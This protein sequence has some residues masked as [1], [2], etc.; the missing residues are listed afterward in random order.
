MM[1]WGNNNAMPYFS[2]LTKP[3]CKCTPGKTRTRWS[4]QRHHFNPI[5]TERY[6]T[7]DH[8]STD[9]NKID[10]I[11]PTPKRLCAGTPKECMYCKFDIPHPS[12]T[13]SDWSSK[14]WDGR[15]AKAKEQMPLFDFRLQEQQLQKTLQDMT[16]DVVP[17]KQ[18]MDL[19]NRMQDL[20]LEQNQDM[21]NKTDILAPPLD[22]PEVKHE[23]TGK[24]ELT[25]MYNM[26]NQEVRLHHKEEKYGIYVSTF[27]YE[28]DDSDLDS[29]MDSNSNATAYLFLE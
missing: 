1:A 21:Q 9:F 10:I 12:I 19:I 24:D 16:Q 15:K 8:D 5:K 14:D 17:D 7:Q 23:E 13:L 27:G 2:T 4:N 25:T 20:T 18:E 28:G 29:K 6:N 11:Q 26:T 22:M 3:K